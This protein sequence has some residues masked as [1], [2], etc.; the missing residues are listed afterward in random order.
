MHSIICEYATM[1]LLCAGAV[2]GVPACSCP[3]QVCAHYTCGGGA[4]QTLH[5]ASGFAFGGHVAST[6]CTTLAN[7]AHLCLHLYPL[8]PQ[9]LDPVG[10]GGGTE[11]SVEMGPILNMRSKTWQK[12]MVK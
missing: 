5:L 6:H 10:G 8:A 4:T 2:R 9:L 3:M 11:A 12:K 1:L 7:D